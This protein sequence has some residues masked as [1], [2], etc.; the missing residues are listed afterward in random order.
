MHWLRMPPS[1]FSRSRSSTSAPSRRAPKARPSPPARRR[2]RRLAFPRPGGGRHGLILPKGQARVSALF[3]DLLQFRPFGLE[4]FDDPRS[5]ESPLAT[6]HSAPGSA[7]DRVH[8][9]RP[10]RIA[11]RGRHF[12]PGDML[13]AADHLAPIGIGGGREDRSAS[14][15]REKRGRSGRSRLE[16]GPGREILLRPDDRRDHFGQ[17]GRGRQ[18]RRFDP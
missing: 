10:E 13:A 17:R 14:S 4:N 8:R 5:A 2:L 18:P 9:H 3:S 6:P 7:L 16:I 11:D 12:G 15:R 1:R